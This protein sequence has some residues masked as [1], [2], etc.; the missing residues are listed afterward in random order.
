MGP[1]RYWFKNSWIQLRKASDVQCYTHSCTHDLLL[2]HSS[3]CLDLR[4]LHF[5]FVLVLKLVYQLEMI[6]LVKDFSHSKCNL[7]DRK[8][9][10]DSGLWIWKR[11][12]CSSVVHHENAG[13]WS[14]MKEFE[15][16]Y[17]CNCSTSILVFM[18]FNQKLL[19]KQLLGHETLTSLSCSLSTCYGLRYRL[20]A[21]NSGDTDIRK[22][23]EGCSWLLSICAKMTHFTSVMEQ[24]DKDFL[25]VIIK[26]WLPVPL[27]LP[28]AV[29]RLDLPYKPHCSE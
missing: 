26:N 4:L 5:P 2:S 17:Y 21:S 15:S 19:Q 3:I 1:S 8:V 13:I 14:C 7:Q 9:V 28:V 25:E 23:L 27:L 11:S 6:I 20:S 16:D 24:R 10:S 29:W 18:S 22:H 12:K